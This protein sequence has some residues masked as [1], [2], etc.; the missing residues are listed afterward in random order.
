MSQTTRC[1]SCGTLFKV[2]ADQLRISDGWVRCGSCQQ[3]FDASAHLQATAPA[4]LL[5]DMAL[6]RLRPP[7]APVRR[8]EPVERLWGAPESAPARVAE[9]ASRPERPA[10]ASTT[11]PSDLA[12]AV[13]AIEP[14]VQS[15]PPPAAPPPVPSVLHVPEPVVPAFLVEGAQ[16]VGAAEVLPSLLAV[17]ASTRP[18]QE[19]P[20]AQSQAAAPVMQ[21]R[22]E[23][24]GGVIEW[25]SIE[26]PAPS[27][28][29]YELPVPDTGSDGAQAAFAPLPEV[30]PLE[31]LPKAT[32]RAFA[33][34]RSTPRPPSLPVAEAEETVVPPT[35]PKKGATQEPPLNKVPDP[36]TRAA[37]PT[38]IPAPSPMAVEQATAEDSRPEGVDHD[39]DAAEPGVQELSFM[40]AARRKAFW[41]KPWVRAALSVVLL[42][43]VALLAAQVAVRERDDLAARVPALRPGLEALCSQWGCVLAPRRDIAAVEVDSSSFQ[44]LRGDEYQFSLVLKN[45][46]AIAVAMPAVELTLTD[47]ADQ[48][49]LR[50]VLLPEHWNAPQELAAHGEWSVSRTLVLSA[51]GVRIT[52]YRVVAF[53]P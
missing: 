36:D 23:E 35:E 16:P 31:L 47:A 39:A 29:G 50:R 52:G 27:S 5:P 10:S 17:G 33:P 38:E 43:S 22:A 49:V 51:T 18:P 30:P 46:S 45:R 40:R 1:P 34:L 21:P 42:A 4:P 3:V 19:V 15:P 26:L 8:A 53:Y 14:P 44:K 48:P 7:P 2:V 6:D 28:A 13:V 12:A 20:A 11:A 9:A 24:D 41:R 25:P 32:D 37:V